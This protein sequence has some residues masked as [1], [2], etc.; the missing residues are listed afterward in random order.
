M[1][2]FLGGLSGGSFRIFELS[3]SLGRL[4]FFELPDCWIH[5][6]PMIVVGCPGGLV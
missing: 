5:N 4:I 2:V 6:N 1:N 3:D